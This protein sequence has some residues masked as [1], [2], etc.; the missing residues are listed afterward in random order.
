MTPEERTKRTIIKTKIAIRNVAILCIVIGLVTNTA[1][2]VVG[3]AM[4]L[5]VVGY[6]LIVEKETE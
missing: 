6:E 3:L 4:S 2:D 5:A 1:L